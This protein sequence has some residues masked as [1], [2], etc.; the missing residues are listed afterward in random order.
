[1]PFSRVYIAIYIRVF[2]IGSAKAEAAQSEGNELLFFAGAWRIEHGTQVPG[3][4]SA[5][6]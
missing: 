2:I 1:L 5:A 4:P 3:A 6:N